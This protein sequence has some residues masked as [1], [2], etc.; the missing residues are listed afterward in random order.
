MPVT[1]SGPGRMGS[2]NSP[3]YRDGHGPFDPKAD[4]ARV[5]GQLGSTNESLWS[6]GGRVR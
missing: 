2:E 4:G 1:D 5:F 3:D 6:P